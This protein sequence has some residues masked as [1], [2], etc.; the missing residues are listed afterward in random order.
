MQQK[1]IVQKGTI[2]LAE[3]FML[4][5]NFKRS[6]I[7]LCDHGS[8]GSVG[9]ILNKPI[10]MNVADLLAE[11]PEFHA[12]VSFGGPVATDTLHYVHSLGELLD[13]SYEVADGG[14]WGGDF[15]QLKALIKEGFVEPHH[16][17]FFIGYSGWTVGQLEEEL[18]VGSWITAE[19]DK[20]YIFNIQTKKLWRQ[21]MHDKGNQ[22]AVI[23]QMPEYKTWN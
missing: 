17:R 2:L 6:A 14:S 21:I 11:F 20:N 3:P 7:L 10:K 23:S 15:N 1:I 12:R 22:Y 13:E 5:P 8:E 9:F 16:I 18:E 4:D 19:M